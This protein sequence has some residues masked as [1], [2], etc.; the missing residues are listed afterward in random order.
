MKKN[1]NNFY[2]KYSLEN[3]CS[4]FFMYFYANNFD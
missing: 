4:K 3:I 1:G 2:L